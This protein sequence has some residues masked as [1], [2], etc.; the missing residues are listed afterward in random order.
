MPTLA[1]L[2]PPVYPVVPHEGWLEEEERISLQRGLER[3]SPERGLHPSMYERAAWAAG[4]SLQQ[5]V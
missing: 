2:A 1:I 4:S 3:R 5:R